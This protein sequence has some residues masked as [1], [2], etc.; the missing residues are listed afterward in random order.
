MSA[1]SGSQP[2][3]TPDDEQ[4]VADYLDSHPDFFANHL[5]LLSTLK[6]PHPSGDAVSLVERHMQAL[7]ERNESLDSKI[8]ELC[9]AGRDNERLSALIHKLVLALLETRKATE[10]AELVEHHLERD[11]QAS[12]I[13]LKLQGEGAISRVFA[14]RD[15][16]IAV[17]EEIP[18]ALDAVLSARRP[19]CGH[20]KPEQLTVL[21]G[22]DIED[23][24]STALIPLSG[25]EFRGVLGIGS[26]DPGQFHAG[27]GTL[28]LTQL[29]E[30]VSHGL[31][32]RLG[33]D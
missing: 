5:Q 26:R 14:G 2:H 11:F 24:R 33:E 20:L 31:D 15:E 21:F 30:L 6:I 10:V 4:M 7:R 18:D 9:E 8:H 27:Q 29:G 32:T 13:S 19:L 3:E 23:I 1:T 22:D 16:F 17:G 25:D 12:H 28:F